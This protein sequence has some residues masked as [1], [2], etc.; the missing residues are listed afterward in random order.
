MNEV[1][2]Y[3]VAQKAT[4]AI[5]NEKSKSLAVPWNWRKTFPHTHLYALV[6]EWEGP[7]DGSEP[8]CKCGCL[9]AASG[10][11]RGFK[12]GWS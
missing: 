12:A 9:R 3:V 8:I 11:E 2:L 7:M 10:T 6:S 1:N 5:V 4:Y